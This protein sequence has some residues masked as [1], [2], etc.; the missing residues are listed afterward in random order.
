MDTTIQVNERGE[1]RLTLIAPGR[2]DYCSLCNEWKAAGSF[3]LF[4]GDYVCLD[5]AVITLA[6]HKKYNAKC[7]R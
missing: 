7:W 6:L 2:K 5:C 3:E 4:G 1:N